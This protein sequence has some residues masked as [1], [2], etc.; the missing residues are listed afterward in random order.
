MRCLLLAAV[1]CGFG[2]SLNG[3]A[4]STAVM[5]D[6]LRVKQLPLHTKVH[7]STDKGGK[8]CLVNEVDDASLTCSSG[9]SG[10]SYPRAEIKSIKLTRYAVST[11][12]G[13]A[14]GAGVGAGIGAAIGSHPT[15]PIVNDTAIRVGI[16][17]VAGG[18]GGAAVGAVT[19]MFRGPLVYRRPA[20]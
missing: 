19:D 20:S 13:A 9:H 17:A 11:I 5:S 1:V 12:G 4:Q 14:I 3:F 16:G 15:H 10:A 2:L 8:T 6:W 7:L 18:L